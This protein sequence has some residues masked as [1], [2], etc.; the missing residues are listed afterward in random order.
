M[1]ICVAE[2]GNLGILHPWGMTHVTTSRSVVAH[3]CANFMLKQQL[4]NLLAPCG[5]AS[6]NPGADGATGLSQGLG[7]PPKSDGILLFSGAYPRNPGGYWL[8]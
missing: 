7:P 5:I 6:G 4:A 1:A 2:V 8:S 3:R